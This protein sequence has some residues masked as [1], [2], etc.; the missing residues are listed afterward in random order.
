MVMQRRL[1]L[2]SDGNV[3]VY[4][5]NQASKWQILWQFI[6]DTCIVHGICGGNNTCSCVPKRGSRCSCLLGYRVKNSNDW[7][8]GCEPMFNLNCN[9]NEATFLEVPGVEFYGY[10]NNYVTN[11]TYMNCLNLCLQDC[12]CKGFQYRYGGDQGSS[13]YTKIQLLNERHS[14]TYEGAIY[15]RLPKSNNYSMEQ[16][17]TTYDHVCSVL[18]HK[19]MLQSNQVNCEVLS[20]ACYCSWSLINGQPFFDLGFIN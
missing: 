18:L 13:C 15:L 11:S 3:R 6:F 9:R 14:P 8:Y 5:R 2:D 10:D 16:S 19:T 12:S 20:M 17:V 1:T 7:S 4:S